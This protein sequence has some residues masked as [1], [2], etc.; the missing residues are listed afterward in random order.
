VLEYAYRA[1]AN[2]V[3]HWIPDSVIKVSMYSLE[4]GLSE[5]DCVFV[6]GRGRTK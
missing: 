4:R 6:C 2:M 3:L 5:R 1:E